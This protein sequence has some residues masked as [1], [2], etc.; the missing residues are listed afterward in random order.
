MPKAVDDF[1]NNRTVQFNT[2]AT[3]FSGFLLSAIINSTEIHM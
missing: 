3:K 1:D 2:D